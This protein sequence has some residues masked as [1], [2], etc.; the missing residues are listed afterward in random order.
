MYHSSDEELAK[1]LHQQLNRKRSSSVSGISGYLAA[2]SVR[3]V[4]LNATQY[5]VDDVW[6][7]K[8]PTPDVK[9]LFKR[10]DQRF[11]KNKLQCV[12]LEWSKRMYNC[13]GICYLRSNKFGKACTIRLSEPL[14]KLRSRKDLVETLLHEMIHA[15]CFVQGIREGNGGHGPTF[16][17][18]MHSINRV[19]GT[20]I[21][22]YHSFHDEVNVYRTHV[23][24][25]NGTCQHREPFYGYVRRTMNRNPGPSDYWWKAHEQSCGGHFVKIREPEKT[26]P[27][28]AAK[29]STNANTTDI[30]KF[31]TPP[32][33]STQQPEA[34]TSEVR[35]N[36]KDA[37]SKK[38]ESPNRSK[39]GSSKSTKWEKIDDDDDVFIEDPDITVISLLD[40]SVVQPVVKPT[41]Q[42]RQSQLRKEILE[43]FDDKTDA[44]ELI[45]D[46]YDD[47]D[48]ADNSHVLNQSV[49]DD[50]F[51]K[52]T[53]MEEFNKN[54]SSDSQKPHGT[55]DE[56]ITCPVCEQ[57]LSR[58][59]L[60]SHMEGCLGIIENVKFRFPGSAKPP[61]VKKPRK[62]ESRSSST[63]SIRAAN[64]SP[65]TPN[66]VNINSNAALV[67]CPVCNVFI[68]EEEAND[69]LDLCLWRHSGSAID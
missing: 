38:F 33:K 42:E 9:A 22:V 59:D 66:V 27:K 15:Y 26:K 44:I 21:S 19:A 29:T 52:D 55:D 12:Q 56:F 28:N 17:S 53:L 31:L 25:C 36:V 63:S 30:R 68:C 48:T 60:P 64:S 49:I 45:D 14:L 34:E 50:L 35:A 8:D 41:R 39:P 4:D 32:R 51:G 10:F 43:S 2:N 13:A 23:W 5:L 16:R 65:K 24:R 11:F 6:E 37:W 62:H 46:E 47:D 61:P 69:H 40:D 20:N 1:Q 58:S 3:N 54:N 7:L 18:I 57:F 67:S